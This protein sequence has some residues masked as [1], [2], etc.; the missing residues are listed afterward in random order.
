MGRYDVVTYVDSCFLQM[1]LCERFSAV[2]PQTD[3][4]FGYTDGGGGVS[5]CLQKD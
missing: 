1:F 5:R 3:G 4:V 2:A